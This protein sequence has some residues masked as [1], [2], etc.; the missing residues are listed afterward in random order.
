MVIVNGKEV[1]LFQIKDG[2][3]DIT[4]KGDLW[5]D[6]QTLTGPSISDREAISVQSVSKIIEEYLQEYYLFLS[7]DKNWKVL[8]DTVLARYKIEKYMKSE[9]SSWKKRLVF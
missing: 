6:Q 2:V 9:H 4:K 7:S 1:C 8:V 5:I 3:F